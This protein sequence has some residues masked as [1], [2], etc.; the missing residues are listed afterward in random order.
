MRRRWLTR[1]GV[2]GARRG[3]RPRRRRL[4][5]RRRRRGGHLGRRRRRTTS[6][7]SSTSSAARWTFGDVGQGR[8]LPHRQHRLR[9]QRRL[10]SLGRVLRQRLDDLQHDRC[11][12]RS[13]MTPFTAGEEGNELVPDLATE[14]PE[15]SADGLTY[16]F[17]I[18]DG[19]TFGPPV[20]R[21]ITSKDILYSFER[22]GTPSVGRPVRLLLHARSRAWR[23]SP[24]ARPR[25]SPAS[26]RPTTRR[27]IFKLTTP[28]GDFLY[29][30]AMPATAPIP[31]GGG[32]VPHPGRRVRP[33]HRHLG[34]VHDRGRRQARHLELRVAE[35]DLGLQPQH[36]PHA[37]AQPELRPGDGQ[38]RDPP[39]QPRPLRDH[40]STPTSTTSSTRSSAVSSRAPS[41]RPRTR[42]LRRYLQDPEHPRAAA[43]Q[44]RRPHLVRLH[45]PHDAAVRRRPR[46]QGDEPRDGPRGHPACLGRPGA[47]QHPD[48]HA[49][50]LDDPD[51]PDYFPYQQA[52]HA[53]A[54]SRPPRPRWR[55]RSTTPTRTAPAT[56][57][58]ARA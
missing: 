19:I 9:P 36:R 51:I 5:R 48:P 39:E 22:I 20:N 41:R 17:T 7:P 10:R 4:R 52:A 1:A 13:L 46:A 56:P 49:P 16:T 45:E 55:S 37:G 23:T 50:E 24:R 38:H 11:S 25:R 34:A 3:R 30:L 18:K 2:A 47:G 14:I 12:A 27:I 44:R 35:A 6:P 29:R 58:R 57:R 33:L 54:T 53:P 32:Q 40:A 15:P 31:R 28:T 8:H 42:S 43:G 21:E 26:R